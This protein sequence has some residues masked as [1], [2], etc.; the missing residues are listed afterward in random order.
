M[1][2]INERTIS[3]A[4]HRYA[5]DIC[6]KAYSTKQTMKA[7][8]VT[9]HPTGMTVDPVS[10]TQRPVYKY[11]CSRENCGKKFPSGAALWR[12]EGFHTRGKSN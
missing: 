5:C 4:R 12:H 9:A 3:A 10:N 7:H 6:G 2:E 8:R 1:K 11:Q